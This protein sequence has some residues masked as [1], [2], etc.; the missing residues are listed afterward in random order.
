MDSCCGLII[1]CSKVPVPLRGISVEVQVKGFV[2]DVC[3]TLRYKNTEEKPI[4]AI[5]VFPLDQDSAVYSFEATVEGKTIVA[6]L[7]ERE[8]AHKTYDEAISQGQEA[9]LLEEDKSSGDIFSC[10]VGN[11]P[12]GQE[13]EVK[14]SFV[15]ELPVESDGAVRFVLPTVLNPRYTP[16]DHDMSVTAAIPRLPADKIPYSLALNAHFQSVYG[17]SKIESNCQLEPIQYTD[18]DKLSAKVSLAQGHKFDKDVELL[19]YY[20]QANTPSAMVEAGLPDAVEGSIMADPVVMLNFYP[21]IPETKEKANSGEFIFLMD[22]SGSM[23]DNMSSEQNA[24][25]RIDSAKETLILLLK[26][27]PLGC[28]FNIFSFGSEFSSIFSE[29][30]AYTQESMAEAV[31]L[32]NQMDADM[33]GTEILE[34]LKRIYKTAGR[35]AHPR[36]LFVFTDG[37]VGNTKFVIDEVRRNAHNHRCFTFGIGD[38]ASTALIKG[39]ARAASGTF[40]FITGKER[41]QPKV[42]QTLKCSLQPMVKDITLTWILPPGVEAKL[43]SGTPTA[44]FQ[45]QKSIVY[46]QLK[47]KVEQGTEGQVSLAY[48]FK[49]EMVANVLRFTLKLT[50]SER[51]TMHRLAAKVVISNL[52]GGENLEEKSEEVQ[53]QIVE[54]SVQSGVISPLTAYVAVNK[55]TKNPVKGPPVQRSIPLYGA[56]VAMACCM[57]MPRMMPGGPPRALACS[58][59]APGLSEPEIAVCYWSDS[60]TVSDGATSAPAEGSPEPK[61]EVCYWPDPA[62][63]SDGATSAPAEGSPEPEI[64]VCYWP[65]PAHTQGGSPEPKVEVCYWPDPASVSDGA[66]SA[67]AEAKAERALFQLISLQ[68]ADGSWNLNSELASVFE[69]SEEA[70]KE[71]IPDPSVDAS[72]WATVLAVMWLHAARPQQRDEWELLEDKA[73][74]WIKAKAAPSLSECVRAGNQLLN[75]SVGSEVFGL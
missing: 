8:Q 29:S 4:E 7:Q 68:N 26:S 48:S 31:K 15:R 56:P 66:T 49:D 64:A 57:P 69:M 55:E 17:I 44:I 52:I 25:R 2:A 74:D 28:Y 36:Q 27:L 30:T 70:L 13:A 40:E 72:L 35:P 47:G 38:G 32:V 12:P 21:N 63:V 46:A 1:S 5:F 60:A 19:A 11:L 51:P 9:F 61:V 18:G 75:C 20:L 3:A 6:E 73:L 24:P 54:T 71:K 53:K 14:L 23:M 67:P 65:D 22:R 10:S 37:E 50:Q 42:L 34:P 58:M 45:G 43:L 16:K 41:M 39:L 62:S 33:G 59:A